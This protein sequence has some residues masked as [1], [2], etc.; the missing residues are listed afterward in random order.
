MINAHERA[1]AGCW[2]LVAGCTVELR[3]LERS[4]DEASRAEQERAEYLNYLDNQH[5]YVQYMY[6]YMCRE[7]CEKAEPGKINPSAFKRANE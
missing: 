6:M 5:M 1:C 4:S 7:Y 2:L 3:E